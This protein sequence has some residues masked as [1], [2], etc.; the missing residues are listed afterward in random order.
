[1]NARNLMY[2]QEV[3]QQLLD[4]VK[5]MKLD[6]NSCGNN[7]D[8]LRKCL[9]TGL[10]DNIAELRHDKGY[11]TISGKM[12]AKIHPSS[13]LHQRYEPQYLVYS[14]IVLTERNYLRHVTE[15]RPE[16]VAEVMPNFM[17]LNRIKVQ[18]TTTTTS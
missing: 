17:Y 15:I 4:I 10:F 1:M 13:V 5:A 18:D 11:L 16:W 7:T 8:Q 3:R 12:R 6:M 9:L 14:E 2:A